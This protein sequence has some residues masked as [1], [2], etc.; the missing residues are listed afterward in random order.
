MLTSLRET[1]PTLK[2]R[3]GVKQLSLFG[4]FARDEA[5]ANSDLDI[6][7]DF[8]KAPT[9]RQYVGLTLYLEDLLGRKV[10]VV[11]KGTLKP[12]VVAAVEKD[13]TEVTGAA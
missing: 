11:T 2:E 1:L 13:L 5:G 12:R 3:Y 8:G 7:V 9:F 6:L 4:S 10:E